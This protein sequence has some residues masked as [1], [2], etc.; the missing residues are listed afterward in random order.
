MK[1]INSAFIVDEMIEK[2][3]EIKASQSERFIVEQLRVIRAYCDLLIKSYELHANHAEPAKKQ[4][5]APATQQGVPAPSKP[6]APA[7][8]AAAPAAKT[9]APVPGAAA[10]AQGEIVRVSTDLVI[11][12]IDTLGGTL[13]RL[14][15]LKHKDS[16]DPT[17]NFVLLGPDHKYEAQS[18][19]IQEGGPNHLTPWVAIAIAMVLG[20]AFVL[21]R[22]FEQLAD[23]FVT[24]IIPFYAMAVAAVYVLR[25]RAGYNPSFRTPGYPVVPALFILSV[26]YLLVNA[27]VDGTSRW[28]TAIVLG[29]ILLGIPV[30]YL[31]V[32]RRRSA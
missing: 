16:A 13:K 21:S 31:T 22:S 24:A 20:I 26:I 14:E 28:P 7:P 27:L 32:G 29:V 5:P 4:A 11:A 3:T 19:L 2:L 25:K 17:R 12:E 23:T 9:P 6:T 1:N 8:A 10:P 30:Y 15:L 18:G